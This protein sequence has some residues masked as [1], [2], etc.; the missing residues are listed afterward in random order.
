MTPSSIE[1]RDL[2][3]RYAAGPAADDA[4]DALR[5][6]SFAVPAG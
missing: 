6:I 4:V 3:Y 2:S 1:V 5:S